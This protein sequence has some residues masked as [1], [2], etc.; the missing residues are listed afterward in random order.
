MSVGQAAR[1][2]PMEY[3]ST[4]WSEDLSVS[5]SRASNGQETVSTSPAYPLESSIV[6]GGLKA[7]FQRDSFEPTPNPNGSLAVSTPFRCSDQVRRVPTEPTCSPP[8]EAAPHQISE[9]PNLL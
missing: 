5:S 9:L 7:F 8:L 4:N 2:R 3:G 6:S 1:D